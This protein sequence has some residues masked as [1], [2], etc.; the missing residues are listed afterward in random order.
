MCPFPPFKLFPQFSLSLVCLARTEK[1]GLLKENQQLK[2][3]LTR[4][5]IILKLVVIMEDRFDDVMS[6]SESL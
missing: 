1:S 6:G 4:G 2:I 5:F 3:H